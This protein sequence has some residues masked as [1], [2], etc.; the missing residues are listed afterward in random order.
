MHKKLEL[1][2]ETCRKTF[3]RH[4]SNYKKR[5]HIFCSHKCQ[6]IFAKGKKILNRRKPGKKMF[7]L[8]SCAYCQ[9]PIYKWNYQIKKDRRHFCNAQCLGK[10]NSIYRIGDNS[11]NWK[12]G[13]NYLAHKILTN[14]RY[15]KIR[16]QVLT[17]DGL[18]CALCQSNIR[19]EVH[20][21]IEKT[22]NLILAFDQNN[23]ITLC[24]KCHI[25][26]TGN[27]ENYIGYFNDIVEKR[28]NSEKP[29]H[30]CEVT[31]SQPEKSEVCRD[32]VFA[33]KG[34]I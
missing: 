1:S 2:C 34:M 9:Q 29:L 10:W 31:P 22:K 30:N 17:R 4:F 5:I 12:G 27:E 18:V 7:F 15:L 21:I 33:P 13:V 14:A 8:V 6:G 24:R 19:L 11:A 23:M 26:I 25:K 20:H 28:T 32:Y 3:Y 16:K